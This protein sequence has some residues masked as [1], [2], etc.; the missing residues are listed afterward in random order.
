MSKTTLTRVLPHLQM[1]N[2]AT[3]LGSS[4]EENLAMRWR[5]YRSDE[6][7]IR[8]GE[9]IEEIKKRFVIE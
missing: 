8:H 5:C 3:T 4:L 9:G 2:F 7:V 1:L 6:S